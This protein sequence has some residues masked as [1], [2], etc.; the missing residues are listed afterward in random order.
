MTPY[1]NIYLIFYFCIPGTVLYYL[2]L[3]I[4]YTFIVIS[5]TIDITIFVQNEG[6]YHNWIG[7]DSRIYM[8]NSLF[9]HNC[10]YVYIRT[11]LPH[12]SL[13]GHPKQD[14]RNNLKVSN[15]LKY[16]MA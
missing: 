9:Y 6:I 1:K 8:V 15:S 7:I 4:E 16:E 12:Y 2:L 5:E 10:L 3:S 13:G 11:N 14:L